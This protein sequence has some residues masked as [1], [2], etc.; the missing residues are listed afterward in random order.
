MQQKKT[1][2]IN[3]KLG[4]IYK[5]IIAVLAITF[6]ILG[7]NMVKELRY[8]YRYTHTTF[9]NMEYRLSDQNF[10]RINEWICDKEAHFDLI[11][12]RE[13]N[14]GA[15]GKYFY[16]AVPYFALKAA[17]N[18]RANDYY[19]RMKEYKSQMGEY[20]NQADVIDEI[21]SVWTD[22]WTK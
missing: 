11:S 5:V 10:N 3:P 1:G 6:I 12:G 4:T 15:V 19:E 8:E 22:S 18:P 13:K 7:I 17:G 14:L 9:E 20:E 16:Q 21:Y 2:N